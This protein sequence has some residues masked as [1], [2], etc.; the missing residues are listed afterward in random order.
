MPG[1]AWT[2]HLPLCQL[3]WHYD[4][5]PTAAIPLLGIFNGIVPGSGCSVYRRITCIDHDPRFQNV[6]ADA[7]T[8]HP[9]E[10]TLQARFVDFTLP[11]DVF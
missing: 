10:L 3:F 7:L 2:T 4:V 9:L 6:K 1:R 11:P 5:S 8:Q